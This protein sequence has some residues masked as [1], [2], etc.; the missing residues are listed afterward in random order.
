MGSHQM[1]SSVLVIRHNLT[2]KL[3]VYII[4]KFTHTTQNNSIIYI[5]LSLDTS[6]YSFFFY[7]TIEFLSF[8][9]EVSLNHGDYSSYR[10]DLHV[11]KKKKIIHKRKKSRVI[12]F[13][14][15]IFMVLLKKCVNILNN[16]LMITK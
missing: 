13:P 10:I 5:Y 8:H 4:C 12:G 15:L 2:R 1:Q 14:T 9:R 6:A 11:S 7:R 3:I 16:S